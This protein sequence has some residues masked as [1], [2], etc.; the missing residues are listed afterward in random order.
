MLMNSDGERTSFLFSIPITD[1]DGLPEYRT[2]DID[3][4]LFDRLGVIYEALY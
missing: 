4:L 3:E 2:P 1:A